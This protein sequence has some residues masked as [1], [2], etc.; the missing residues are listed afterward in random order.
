MC[1]PMRRSL[2]AYECWMLDRHVKVVR[3]VC[4]PCGTDAEAREVAADLYER[5]DYAAGLAGFE[6]RKDGIR[7]LVQ[8]SQHPNCTQED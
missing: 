8:L 3:Q 1:Q 6:I 7:L 2:A 5:D 4:L